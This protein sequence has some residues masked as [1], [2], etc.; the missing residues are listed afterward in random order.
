[1]IQ[2]IA[3]ENLIQHPNNPRKEY[4]EIDDLAE[5]IKAQGVL[6]NLTVVATED[7]GVYMVVIGN[8]RLAAAKQAGLT[9]L[10]CS[11]V[12]MDEK[13]Q[14]STMLLENMQRNDLTVFEQA[15]GFQMCL[16]LGMTKDELVEETGLSKSTI[17]RR[18]EVLSLDQKKVKEKTDSGATI[19]DFMKLEKIKS[20]ET[21]NKVMESIGSSNFEY[22]LERAIN[23]EK[24]IRIKEDAIKIL[25]TF[26]TE[27]TKKT[28]EYKHYRSYWIASYFDVDIIEVPTEEQEYFYLVK[29]SDI[30]VLVIGNEVEEDEGETE[31]QRQER[32]RKEQHAREREFGETFL[33]LRLNFMK[34]NSRKHLEEKELIK[35]AS[36]IMATTARYG[37]TIKANEEE[38]VD[39]IEDAYFYTKYFKVLANIDTDKLYINDFLAALQRNYK[40]G[41]EKVIYCCLESGPEMPTDWQGK[42]DQEKAIDYNH[43]YVLLESMGY[44]TSTEEKK[45]LDGTHE[46]YVSCDE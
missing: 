11:I 43:L 6:Q 20:I 35:Y 14:A 22:S 5:S 37:D 46:V 29:G 9:E 21:R 15:Q 3:I 36:L 39:Y 4:R 41:I 2:N 40:S 26:A 8:R 42:Y 19:F 16:D 31:W 13:T 33:N 28:S 1:M 17:R 10:P 27:I 24:V 25:D 45:M 44:K 30:E 12:E 34:S 18:L 7:E 23:E 32:E 38:N